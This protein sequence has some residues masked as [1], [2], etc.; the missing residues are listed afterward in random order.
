ME[1]KQIK[2]TKEVTYKGK[3]KLAVKYEGDDFFQIEHDNQP[4]EYK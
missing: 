2:E 3:K 1:E 4:K